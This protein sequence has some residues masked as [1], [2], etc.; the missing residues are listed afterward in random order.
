MRP[1]LGPLLQ[2]RSIAVI[3]ASTQ[4]LKV[5]GMPI[6]LL[7][8]NGY[9][10]AIY[11]VHRTAATIQD[12]PAYPSLEAIGQ[13]VDLA[14]IA[15]PVEGCEEAM[16]QLAR[17][18]T[19]AAIVF[20][21]GFAETG[22]GGLAQQQAMADTARQYGIALLGPNCLGAMNLHE[23]MFA[24][25]SPVVLGGAPAPGKVALVS[26]SGAFGGYAFSLAREAG[27]GLGYWITTGNEAGIQAADAIHWL[28]E[29]ARTEVILVYLEG[30][31][32]EGRLRA[33]LGAARDAGKPVAIVKVGYTLVGARA[34]RLHTGSDT[35]NDARYQAIFDEFN[36]HRA[37]TIGELFRLGHV[38][39]NRKRRPG[40]PLGRKLRLGVLSISGG[41]GI[42][43]ADR[44]Q[45]HGFDMPPLP[46][47]PAT[48]LLARIPFAATAN[49]VDVTGQVFSQ[50]EVL[51]AA[52]ADVARCGA[53][54]YIAAFMAGAGNAPGVWTALQPC[55]AEL[56]AEAGA[57]TMVFSGLFNAQQKSWL[58]AQG[59]LVYRE[60]AEAVDAVA[61]L[62]RAAP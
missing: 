48:R 34:A 19:R 14:I 45:Q 60:P 22:E 1:D 9:S 44:A 61:T 8:E 31:R 18:G 24:T 51:V 33:A 16:Q 41:V 40:P 39:A 25:F 7:R 49:P 32:D 27:L 23:R 29:D 5:G 30:A 37:Y 17:A 50:P 6:R 15:V 62:A 56:T 38:L 47:E 21:S 54:D 36:V 3:G 59:C 13:P 11:P 28:A 52:L 26:Q 57:A 58:E 20:T 35:G 53:Y 12:L 2:P 4:A 42:M 55:V 10:G 43:M 46:P